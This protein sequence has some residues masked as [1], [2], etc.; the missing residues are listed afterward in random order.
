MRQIVLLLGRVI[1][2]GLGSAQP[3]VLCAHPNAEG[4]LQHDR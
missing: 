2:F 1:V 3:I 4:Q